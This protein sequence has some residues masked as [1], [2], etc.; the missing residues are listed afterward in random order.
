LAKNIS[1]PYL[2]SPPPPPLQSFNINVR[3]SK[4]LKTFRESPSHSLEKTNKI[5]QQAFGI[6]MG[7]SSLSSLGFN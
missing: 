2:L 5:Q 3:K 6:S 7:V 4:N 1:N